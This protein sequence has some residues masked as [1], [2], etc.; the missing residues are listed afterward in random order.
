MTP[1]F[2][3]LQAKVSEE[4]REDQDKIRDYPMFVQVGETPTQV[5]IQ[6]AHTREFVDSDG[7]DTHELTVLLWREEGDDKLFKII[8]TCK[9]PKGCQVQWDK[10]ECATELVGFDYEG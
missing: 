1:I 10:I 2:D 4:F 8:K 7:L 5:F 6:D 3:Y 9:A